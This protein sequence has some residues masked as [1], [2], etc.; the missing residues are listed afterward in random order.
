MSRT[1]IH[2]D[3]APDLATDAE[4]GAHDHDAD[5][6]ATGATATHSADTTAV[7]GIVDT[8]ALSLTSHDHDT[9]YEAVG[10]IA[11]H[12]A[13]TTAVHG[14]VDTSAL[15][16][17]SHDH[18]ADYE[19]SGAIATHSADSTS[20]H[21]ITDTSVL[22]TAAT[23]ATAITNHE[24]AANPHATYLTQAEG[25]AAYQPLDS[26][27]TAIAALTT[28]AFGRALLALADGAALGAAH[29]HSGASTTYA[30]GSFTVATGN[31]SIMSKRL[32]LTTTQRATLAG[33]ARL[34]IT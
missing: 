21:G 3:D 5:Y 18:D 19:A 1:R 9:D 23:L 22:A 34:R 6:E 4:I 17:T 24:A 12:S 30:P 28:T 7:H 25:D 32:E 8:S 2:P 26:D 15:S 13:D 20:I 27:L 16:L 33:T 11:T 14:I 31:Y 29:S 10:G